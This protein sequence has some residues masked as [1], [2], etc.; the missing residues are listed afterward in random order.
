PSATPPRPPFFRSPIGRPSPYCPG[1]I[2]FP[3]P[4]PHRKPAAALILPRFTCFI[5]LFFVIW[6]YYP[7]VL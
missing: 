4:K 2:L 3:D 1:K 5:P 6:I 7:R